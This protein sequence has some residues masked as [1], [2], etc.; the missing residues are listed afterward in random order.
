MSGKDTRVKNT[1]V[2]PSE[3]SIREFFQGQAQ[4]QRWDKITTAL[5]R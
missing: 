1:R 4:L 5:A 3:N 2:T